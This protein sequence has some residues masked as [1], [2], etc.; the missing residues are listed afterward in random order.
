MSHLPQRKENNCLNCGTEV[1]GR[2]CHNCGQ[3]NI[4]PEE[5]TWHFVVHFFNDVT[6]FDGKFFT[7]LKDLL[8]KPG[9]LSKEYMIG[10]KVRYLN[11]VRMYLFTSFI[12]FLIFFSVTHVSDSTFKGEKFT[13][14]GKTE[15]A[16]ASLSNEDLNDF[17]KN[18]N[19]GIP[20]S[21]TQLNLYLDS[22]KKDAN[23]NFFGSHSGYQSL[24]Q[25][26]SAVKSK[27]VKDGWL[28]RTMTYKEIE[29]NSKYRDQQG[30]FLS[31]FINS[32]MHHFPQIL[33]ISLPFCALFLKLLY[34]RH[35]EFYYVSHGIFSIH[36][37]IFVFIAM[38]LSMGISRI[39]GLLNWNWLDFINGLISIIIFF[40]LYKAM[41][42]FY[43]QG[44]AKTF[45]KYFIFLIAF[46]TLIVFLFVFFAFV[47]IFQV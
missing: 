36:F 6:H 10:R 12:F 3:E 5:S 24:K 38:L 19:K 42:N 30:K 17:T 7:T 21:R 25:Y 16:I 31:D 46:F 39:E 22:V 13:F 32:L 41:R 8:F 29:I 1:M 44:R 40:Y 28:K 18:I 23:I 2:Y 15:Q 43:Q 34:I 20:M 45:F 14:R 4:D 11:P 47:S 9:Y 33:F 37:Y 35:K 27:S 26:D